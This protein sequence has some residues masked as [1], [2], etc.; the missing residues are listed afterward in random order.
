MQ[1]NSILSRGL[2]N[3]KCMAALQL[4][5]KSPA[6]AKERFGHDPDVNAFVIEFGR[7]MGDHFTSLGEKES[8]ST[9]KVAGEKSPKGPMISEVAPG[10]SGSVGAMGPLSKAA[11]QRQM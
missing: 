5:Q 2:Q 4:M 10:A 8:K 3:P 9:S 1:K 11:L 6:E 7:V